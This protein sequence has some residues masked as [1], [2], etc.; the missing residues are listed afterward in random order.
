VKGDPEGAL[1]RCAHVISG[2]VT[3][4]GQK[5]FYLET[6]CCLVTPRD[7]DELEIFSS[8]QEAQGVQV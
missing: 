1:A 5:H 4:G 8:T 2:E 7:A 3:I 6:Q